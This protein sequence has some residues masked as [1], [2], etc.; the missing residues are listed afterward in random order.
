MPGWH[1]YRHRVGRYGEDVA[2]GFLARRGARVVKRNVTV[3]RGEIDLVVELGGVRTAVE[4]KTVVGEAADPTQAFTAAK[5]A[6]VRRLAGALEPAAH[7]VDLI[8]VRL[9]PSGVTVR[10]TPYAG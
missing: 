7:R 5:A 1:S 3:G 10:W 2:A 4:V 9:G 6:Q 8:T